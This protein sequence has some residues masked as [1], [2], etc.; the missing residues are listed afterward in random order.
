MPPLVETVSGDGAML[1][2]GV[3]AVGK[4]TGVAETLPNREPLVVT[5]T[6]PSAAH[7]AVGTLA[8]APLAHLAARPL[9]STWF[10]GSLP[11]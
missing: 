1:K 9:G 3:A 7:P 6:C 11:T 10:K 5:A 8:F 2:V 4:A